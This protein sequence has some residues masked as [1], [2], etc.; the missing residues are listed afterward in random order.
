[1]FLA[2]QQHQLYRE[3]MPGNPERAAVKRVAQGL[4]AG[5]Y[6]FLVAHLVAV[7]PTSINSLPPAKAV[8]Q[9]PV[10]EIRRKDG[11]FHTLDLRHYLDLLREDHDLQRYFLR[12]WAVGALLMLGDE[13]VQHDY[14]DHAPVLELVYHLRNG[15]A[16]GNRFN[17][18]ESGKKRLNKYPAHNG[19]AAV[20]SPTGTVFD[21]TA[22]LN[23]QPVLFDFIGPADI[24]DVLQSVEM[25][26]S[27]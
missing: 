12:T 17:L 18:T 5:Y 16:H 22:A 4:A 9:N 3:N 6:S 27:Q 19:S 21:V 26:L 10:G 25:H 7:N 20:R 24:I 23:G 11:T 8:G 1:L 15:V 14:F 13:L 2:A